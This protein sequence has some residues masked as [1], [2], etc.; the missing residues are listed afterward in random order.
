MAKKEKTKHYRVLVLTEDFGNNK[1]GDTL[2]VETTLATRL[3]ERKVAVLENQKEVQEVII[4]KPKKEVK[5]S[6][7][8]KK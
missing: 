6:K 1:D 5:Q 2:R 8:K 7:T 3:I 4:E